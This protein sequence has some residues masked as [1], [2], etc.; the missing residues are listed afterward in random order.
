M[1]KLSFIG[2]GIANERSVPLSGLDRMKEA[3]IIHAEF[4]TSILEEGSIQRLEELVG[5]KINVLDREE[6]EEKGSVMRSLEEVDRVCFLTAG[7]PLT[8]TTHQEIRSD[9]IRK[10]VRVE[11]INSGSIYIAAAGM[12]GL[13]HYKFGRA[14][15]LAIPEGNYFPTSPL[16]VIIENLER[17][18][19]SLVLLDIQAHRG[20][21]MTADEGAGIILE[22]VR[23]AQTSL[24]RE[25]TMAVAVLRA[26]R[27]DGAVIYSDLSSLSKMDT[28]PPPHCLIIPG[29]LHFMEE[30][31]LEKFRS[32]H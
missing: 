30:E 16:D 8:A 1:K 7:D 23:K 11:I 20:R 4:F 15:T 21:Y 26:G 13:Q 18:L 28:G 3:G 12:A 17:G 24:I 2:L 27:D 9:A 19:H 22:M 32:S 10:G 14:T 5:K 6:V 25:K 29:K 31:I